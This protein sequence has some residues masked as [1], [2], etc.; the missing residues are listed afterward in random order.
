VSWSS[1]NKV[2]VIGASCA[3]A[4]NRLYV[5]N[6]DRTG[7]QMIL[8]NVHYASW[9]P[10]GTKLALQRYDFSESTW[11][12]WTVNEDG[13]NPQ[14]LTADGINCGPS[15]SPDGN[16]I[17]FTRNPVVA[18]SGSLW[19]MNSDGS[20][21]H[22]ITTLGSYFDYEPVWTR[23]NQ[24]PVAS[25]I[26]ATAG[27]GG[28]I[29][30]SGSVTVAYGG[31]QSFT[32][33]PDL[34]YHVTDVLVD[35][36]SVGAVTT[37]TF[38]NVTSNHT[39][40][41][42]FAAAG[43]VLAVPTLSAPLD[44]S[45]NV[46]T[47]PTLAWNASSGSNQYHLEVS[48]NSG[49]TPL[50][51]DGYT[52]LTYQ[53]VAGLANG[54]T[55]YWRVKGLYNWTDS[56]GWSTAW[57]FTASSPVLGVPTLSTPSDG[58][59]NVST[60]PTLAWNTSSGSNQYHLEV[61]AN[62]GFTP[63]KFDGYTTLTYQEVAGLANGTTYY[64][65][66]K[67]LYN[68]TDSS[69][70]TAVWS[71][72]TVGGSAPSM[73]SATAGPGGSIAPSG[74][75]TVA[76]GAN[77]SFSI[78]PNVGCH[79]TDVLVDAM[80][81]GAVTTYPFTNV[82]SNHTIEARF[83]ADNPCA[84][85]KILFTRG[86]IGSPANGLYTMDPGGNPLEAFLPDVPMRGARW[87]EDNSKIAFSSTASTTGKPE[88]F[89]FDVAT[90]D[91]NQL[92][93]G[94]AYGNDNPVFR[95][96]SKIWYNSA[97]GFWNNEVY[98]V[99]S[100][101]SGNTKLTDF[102]SE[103]KQ[104][105]A[106]FDLDRVRGKIY[107]SLQDR[108]WAPS[109]ELYSQNLDFSGTRVPFTSESGAD[110]YARLSPS[111]TRLVW[112]HEEGAGGP[113]NVYTMN[114]DGTGRTCLTNAVGHQYSSGVVWSPDESEII[115]SFFD[116]SQ[117]DLYKV[118]ATG[119]TPTNLTKTPG[120]HEYI[121]DWKSGFPGSPI[122]VTTNPAD[123]SV[124]A[125][126]AAA[127][128]A[129]AS[130]SP[131]VQWQTSTDGGPT[132]ADITGATS[133]SL[134]FV[135]QIQDNGHQYRAVFTNDCGA[136]TSNA[137][138]LTVNTPPVVTQQPG[139]QTVVA[140]A[141]V[142]LAAAATGSPTPTVHWEVSTDGGA[143]FSDIDGAK[144]PE[145]TLNGVTTTQNGYQYRAVFSNMCN[146]AGAPS[147]AA[148]LAVL[149]PANIYVYSALHKVGA[150]TKPGSIKTP[151]AIELKVFDKT[152]VPPPDPKD[153]GT[154]W[155]SGPGLV[156]PV[157][158]ISD[159]QVVD[160][161]DGQ[162]YL[163]SIIVPSCGPTNT[164]TSGSYLV[165]GK[166]MVEETAF[167]VGSPT[168]PLTTGSVTQKH[169]QIV[170][171]GAGKNMAAKT[172]VVFGSLLIVTEPEC[173]EFTSDQEL[174]PI[175][176]ESIEGDWKVTVH[177]ETPEGFVSNPGAIS[178][179]IPDSTLQAVQF[180]VKD[181]GSSWTTTKLTHNIKHKGKDIT[182]TSQTRM[183]NKKNGKG[184]NVASNGDGQVEAVTSFIPTDYMLYQNY[185]DPFNPSTQIEYDLAENSEVR[186]GI[187][188]ILG[189][190]II[191][192][193]DGIREAGRYHRTWEG[194]DANGSPVV[195]GVYFLRM[196][197]QSVVSDRHIVALKKMMLLR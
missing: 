1:K 38:A 62:S 139:D 184:G 42:R 193:A 2:A 190:E 104:L 7:F 72:T 64:W 103:G 35:G 28:S 123:R 43:P 121:L 54:T 46:S 65:R 126:G 171:N 34:G 66:V 143:T 182:L 80:S 131:T 99:N 59:A 45:T 44:G 48:A 161:G 83:S 175:I 30:P 4:I 6:P 192:L 71:F 96:A 39:I 159:P 150:G 166:A 168:D 88:I 162:C 78:T 169:L 3:T 22:E 33:T 155:A 189:R 85:S 138:T 49:F 137:A 107:Y 114:V 58:S 149:P 165:I 93:F 91:K 128:S 173:L 183:V 177:A 158:V 11:H 109:A 63:L 195:S 135:S 140:G 181:V 52:T 127:F 141:S 50:N 67:G 13:S 61:S 187:Y 172:T 151:L 79:I 154:I 74:S 69:G 185:P 188:D 164:A 100:D 37:Y 174:M 12:I 98:E 160:F 134:S 9:S 101:A 14:R 115:Y 119:G 82:T 53:E 73:I 117:M 129:A 118:P 19:I 170:Q 36:V 113:Q 18:G 97:C 186:V 102:L 31:N 95:S 180:T 87:S 51:F 111:R 8:E 156:S 130:G 16:Q 110:I 157:V 17:V 108:G 191:T 55:Y 60:S 40:E 89:I 5:F 47:S 90:H 75:V 70:W 179:D 116:G 29:A 132:W 124:C 147:N 152:K 15:W 194:M 112:V 136:A 167:Y 20:N 122:I 142:K 76:Y 106:G 105:H 25:T 41:A 196:T 125:G 77:Q 120:Y 86:P 133:P 24:E 23:L 94:S 26:A 68:W 163:Y 145:L 176:Y 84:A 21:L 81:V 144:S 153:F 146:E 92:T 10:D 32:V 27:V 197:A 148:H 57:S 56:S 178:A